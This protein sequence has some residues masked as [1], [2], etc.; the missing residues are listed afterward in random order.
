M[1][2]IILFDIL[3]TEFKILIKLT[4]KLIIFLIIKIKLFNNHKN[5]NI[6]GTQNKNKLNKTNKLPFPLL[7][8]STFLQ[9]CSF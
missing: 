2:I 1:K 8:S 5:K 6:K 9:K 7:I 4:V 3:T